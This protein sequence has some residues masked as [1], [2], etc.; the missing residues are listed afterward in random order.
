MQRRLFVLV[1]ALVGL[2]IFA[3]L[4]SS[5]WLGMIALI[6]A[7]IVLALMFLAPAPVHETEPATIS[8]PPPDLDSL[9]LEQIQQSSQ[10]I[11][12]SDEVDEAVAA[13]SRAALQFSGAQAALVYRFEREAAQ[14]RLLYQHGLTPEVQEAW[15]GIPV[16]PGT[17]LSDITLLDAQTIVPP[18]SFSQYVNQQ[19]QSQGWASVLMI[20]LQTGNV[21][22]GVMLLFF[23]VPPNQSTLQVHLPVLGMIS[24]QLAVFLDNA[25]LF[26]VL[27]NYAL[28]MA[29]LS[30]LA[31]I[32]AAA[33]E[34]ETLAQ[35]ITHVLTDLLESPAIVLAIQE[36]EGHWLNMYERLTLP[37]GTVTFSINRKPTSTIPELSLL[38][39]ELET[40]PRYFD[41]QD[42]KLSEGL[43][44]F[45]STRQL[46]GATL[47]PLIAANIHDGVLVIGSANGK[48]LELAQIQVL[49]M[50]N[51]QIAAQIHNVG[52]YER[53]QTALSR[54]LNELALIEDI[55]RQISTS[56]KFD[57]IS[58]HML[59]A[60]LK[61]TNSETAMLS[62]LTDGGKLWS[63]M[64]YDQHGDLRRSYRARGLRDSLIEQVTRSRRPHLI[65][66]THLGGGVGDL[67]PGS[68]SIAAVPLERE[69]GVIGVLSVASGEPRHFTDEQLSFLTSLAGHAVISIENARLL[70][71]HEYQI[72]TLR[73]LQALTLRLSSADNTRSVAEAVLETAREMLDA[74]EAA[75]FRYIPETQHISM[76]HGYAIAGKPSHLA[77]FPQPALKAAQTGEIKIQE[78]PNGTGTLINVPIKGSN[79]VSE[80][81]S[82]LFGETYKTR[83]RDL[84][85][86]LLLANQAAGHLENA[87]LHEQIRATSNRTR[88]ILTSTRDGVILLDREGRLLEC[89]PAAERLLNFDKEEFLGKHIVAMLLRLM[90]SGS[91]GD[92]GYDRSGLTALARQL[93]LEPERITR[94]EFSRAIG[95]QMLYIEEIGSPVRNSSG[96][97]VGRLL[98][99][100][101]M[102][103]QNLLAQYR[104]EITHM[105]VH[106]LRGPLWSVIT[107]IDLALY[108]LDSTGMPLPE[109]VTRTLDIARNSAISL[110]NIVDSLLDISRLEKREM[111]LNRAPISTAHL[112]QSVMESLSGI[113]NDA[114]VHVRIE[115]AEDL[116]MLDVDEALIRRVLINLLDNA[117]RHT[118]EQ[119]EILIFAQRDGGEERIGVADSGIGIPYSERERV[120]ERFRQVKANAPLRG[121]KGSG[122][123]LT[124]CKLAVEAHGGRIWVEANSP[125]PGACFVMRLPVIHA[126]DGG[127]TI[128]A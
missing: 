123:G 70:E 15:L 65:A 21:R 71:E 37:D 69:G 124:F 58:E 29:Q 48:P 79:G 2:G 118:P 61:A 38:L 119:G 78:V 49:E 63:V 105:M 64:Q 50:A 39:T 18:G 104:E 95:S 100:R 41:E 87:A 106:D 93:R 19:A 59:E 120:F 89:N 117:V 75:L 6:A 114:A 109:N 9:T 25:D 127:Q 94:R 98:V 22:I 121:S 26:G 7:L 17:D 86:L 30:H 60:A 97:I 113:V 27:E 73:S 81:L 28:Q 99:F 125:L 13:A 23:K 68:R 1:F 116:P 76:I 12:F 44:E 51:S 122:L 55:A 83:Q 34:V 52:L 43:R 42:E 74:N 8:A 10:T 90:E 11:L 108:D 45:I 92:F 5:A 84:N 53:T 20:P 102:T 57:L 103:E 32:A 112:I 31:R 33:I 110:R 115:I 46:Q 62:L 47:F 72:A 35:E 14:F 128:R 85:S 107:G 56:L 40:Q 67:L 54:R 16:L 88:A 126:Y 111:P 96:E 80:V 24:V 4:I 3:I 77:T 36:G 91:E 82:L 66:D 101:D